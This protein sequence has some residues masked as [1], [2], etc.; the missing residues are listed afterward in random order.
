MRL[1]ASLAA[2]PL[3][4]LSA[5]PA[6]AQIGDK[7]LGQIMFTTESLV[8]N[9]PDTCN[10]CHPGS[11]ST[12]NEG[13]LK[14]AS[15]QLLQTLK[16]DADQD[17]E[18]TDHPGDN[19][20]FEA[21]DATKLHDLAAY[22]SSENPTDFKLVGHIQKQPDDKPAK[23]AFVTLSNT[24][25]F[26]QQNIPDQATG[27]AGDYEFN[28][29]PAGDYTITANPLPKHSPSPTEH[30]I[31]VT[32]N[33]GE[34]SCAKTLDKATK[35]L[36][37]CDFEMQSTGVGQKL[38]LDKCF[39][40]HEAPAQNIDDVLRGARLSILEA[41]D[42][43]HS[44]GNAVSS[45]WLA[46]ADLEALALYL[47]SQ[48]KKYTIK[49]SM[50][51]VDKIIGIK[52]TSTYLPGKTT[53][54]GVNGYEFTN[55]PAG[56]YDVTPVHMAYDFTPDQYEVA[57]T[58][59]GLWEDRS[60]TLPSADSEPPVLEDIDFTA[61]MAEP[62][63]T[64]KTLYDGYCASCHGTD[65]GELAD[66]PGFNFFG[67]N[68]VLYAANAMNIIV[69]QRDWEI[70]LSGTPEKEAMLA[71]LN[72]LNPPLP[73]NE[74]SN[75]PNYN[76]AFYEIA[77]YVSIMYPVPMKLEGWI[78]FEPDWIEFD[79]SSPSNLHGTVPFAEVTIEDTDAA[80]SNERWGYDLYGKQTVTADEN[81]RYEIEG[82]WGGTKRVHVSKLGVDFGTTEEE[83]RA[84]SMTVPFPVGAP[85]GQCDLE[86]KSDHWV[87]KDWRP[88]APNPQNLETPSKCGDFLGTFNPEVGLTQTG[89]ELFIEKC[90]SCHGGTA[91]N[92]SP[93]LDVNDILLGA[94]LSVLKD[95]RFHSTPQRYDTDAIP[96]W[97]SP[98]PALH[99]HDASAF[100]K[101]NDAL[102]DAQLVSLSA[103]IAGFGD[104][105]SIC[106]YVYPAYGNTDV[107]GQRVSV[108]SETAQGKT[109]FTH[110]YWI[111]DQWGSPAPANARPFAVSGL[112]PGDYVVNLPD[113][114][115]Q[116][117][118]RDV[119][120]SNQ[121]LQ[122][123]NY[124]STIESEEPLTDL[125][126]VDF[127]L[128]EPLTFS[129]AGTAEFYELIEE[130]KSGGSSEYWQQSTCDGTPPGEE[131][132]FDAGNFIESTYHDNINL[133]SIENT[134]TLAGPVLH[135][136]EGTEFTATLL[137]DRR[138]TIDAIGADGTPTPVTWEVTGGSTTVTLRYDAA[139]GAMEY[140]GSTG[141]RL[142]GLTD[143][144]GILR[145]DSG[146]LDGNYVIGEA[147]IEGG[148][149]TPPPPVLVPALAAWGLLAMLSSLIVGGIAQL[150]GVGA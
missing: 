86:K 106:G 110:S 41:L 65:P 43:L 74:Q 144:D 19:K 96:D 148:S 64:G 147:T 29:R 121:I 133:S 95:I 114:R 108:F 6:A 42:T 139:S 52:L 111:C 70:H 117:G 107:V 72:A 131:V 66:D 104:S 127:W 94:R 63:A 35:T 16:A 88:P 146:T 38:Y 1:L 89:Q 13:H 45:A 36:A 115:T 17:P 54:L 141:D 51:V 103:Y 132:P 92:S 22:L 7:N 140:C 25:L 9:P 50:D 21:L 61:V 130:M 4:W 57:V 59:S 142:L 84:I 18:G 3:L 76:R 37:G 46:N 79:P 98:L 123:R 62:F 32:K 26:G 5:A 47:S 85:N 28:G 49:G 97:I 83:G 27:A 129:Q 15:L 34:S 138:A 122:I 143:N 73:P 90:A 134:I 120:L 118:T 149:Y 20:Y 11:G 71:A 68:I 101:N 12:P 77:A 124:L 91:P 44:N 119:L 135:D 39:T 69:M 2:L 58:D 102:S 24:Y 100:I 145:I 53:T 93:A 150:R 14:G 136:I 60:T 10:T 137:W 23:S 75:E 78:E 128:A 8:Q 99:V 31:T 126:Q 105:Y 109:T 113:V 82:I 125:P 67:Y 55:V 48:S 40:C 56:D 116:N 81:G 33:E 87:V 80:I 30:T 112:R